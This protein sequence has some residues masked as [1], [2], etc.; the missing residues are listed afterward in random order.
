M[1]MRCATVVSA[2]SLIVDSGSVGECS[3]RNIT[4]WSPGLTFWYEGGAGICG[5]SC[6]AA[7]AI[8]A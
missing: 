6:R 1:E 8:I 5:G 3:T 4:G 7:L 2:Y